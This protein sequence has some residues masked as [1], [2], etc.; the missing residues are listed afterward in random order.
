MSAVAEPP[1]QVGPNEMVGVDLASHQGANY[2]YPSWAQFAIIKAS[3]GHSYQ[4]E[5]RGAQAANARARGLKVGWYHY[6]LEPTNGGGNMEL[7]AT[8]LRDA[9]LPYVLAGDTIW[10]DVEEFLRSVGLDGA[11][12]GAMI[13]EWCDMVA[14]FFG[15]QVGI[16][17]A[18]WYLVAA[19]LTAD[20][21]LAKRPFWVAS[22]QDTL[23]SEEFLAPWKVVKVW[24]FNAEGID[25]DKFF[26]DGNAWDQLGVPAAHPSTGDPWDYLKQPYGPFGHT[27]HPYFHAEYSLEVYGYPLGP[28]ALYSDGWTRQ[29]FENGP[30]GSNGR[31]Q[32]RREAGGQAL[33]HM[34]G[35]NVADWPDV[36]PL[37]P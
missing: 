23:P 6:W 7:E 37:L 22:W 2:D 29:L 15:C 34:S 27:V 26:G 24:Q 18:T 25:K 30:W 36:H 21:R 14:D 19:A 35:K 11:D 20:S 8:N 17:C 16:Y 4:N 28:A 12:A 9:I 31:S 3:G 13:D 10:L 1:I 5:F 33:T 32:P